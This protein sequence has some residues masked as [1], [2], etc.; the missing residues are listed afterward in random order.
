MKRNRSIS[1]VIAAILLTSLVGTLQ[2]PAQELS[3]QADQNS[4]R[5][6]LV[7]L[8]T[9]GGPN[10]Y[11]PL[12]PPYH[13]FLPSAALSRSGTFAGSADTATPDPYNPFCFI[14]CFVSHA[15][16]WRNG[17]LTDL[18]ALPGPTG[19]SS[20]ATWISKNGLIA[21]FS[22]NG[23]IDPLIGA[24][25][26]F[27]V[28]W[29][30]GN[31]IN[32]GTLEGGY[33]SG[34]FSVNNSGRVVGIASSLIPDANSLF[35][36]NTQ[37]RAFLWDNG[38][39][40]DLGTL[41]GGT[42]AMALF[43]NERGQIVGQSYSANSVVPPASGCTDSPL[44]LYGFFWDKGQMT[45][46]GTLGGNCT[47]PYS[48]NNRGQVVGQSNVTGDV[49]SHPF[50]WQPGKTMQDLGTLGGNY[51]YAEWLNDAGTVVGTSTNP[52]DQALIPFRWDKG[53]MTNLGTLPGN[54][55]SAADAINSSGQMVGGSGFYD[56]PFFPACTDPVEHAVLWDHGQTVDLNNFVPLGTDLT[57]NEAFFINDRGEISGIGT[58]SN[59]DQRT[60]LLIPCGN[61][62][63]NSACVN[64]MVNPAAATRDNSASVP[65]EPRRVSPR[66]FRTL[67]RRGMTHEPR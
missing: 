62:P 13:D 38:V 41:P 12:L 36:T 67:G 2:S 28:L 37:A 29:R 55:C 51:G 52:G 5:Y 35:G 1:V 15:V 18:G 54:A 40:Q 48:L 44:T 42:D 24:P 22:E 3:G 65:H 61:G 30:D 26:L 50:L 25:A 27:G 46:I 23:E 58:D 19:S 49:T 43:I 63:E 11:L 57:L 4:R 14:D 17:S 7:D 21:G 53:V 31:I 20:A 56:A 6:R 47:F 39:M 32:L 16:T 9:L 8:G 45:D 34:A 59:G 64:S 66:A 10:S 33:E 60:F